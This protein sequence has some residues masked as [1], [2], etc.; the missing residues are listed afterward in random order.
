MLK[1]AR[2]AENDPGTL[3]GV[4]RAGRTLYTP[5]FPLTSGKVFY[6]VKG[7]GFVY[8][9]IGSHIMI[10][11]PLHGQLVRTFNTGNRFQWIAHDL[12]ALA[13]LYPASDLF[14]FAGLAD[15][16]KPLYLI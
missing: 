3:G 2:G 6:L 12:S 1:P 10:A 9:G 11:G 7:S 4:V 8:A 14:S 13:D 15:K 5:T 16:V